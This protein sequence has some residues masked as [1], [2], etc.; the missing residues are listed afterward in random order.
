MGNVAFKL[1]Y[2]FFRAKRKT[3]VRFTSVVAVVG[4]AVGVASLI[5][6]QSLARGFQDEMRDKILKNTAHI[7]IFRGDGTE[8]SNWQTIRE[9]I[10]T[11]NNI[12]SIAPAS[13]ANVVLLTEQTNNYAL[14]YAEAK[15]EFQISIEQLQNENDQ[16]IPISIG[17][18]LA[19]KANLKIGG[20]AEIITFDRQDAPQ[21]SEI[22]IKEISETGLYEYDS[23][24]IFVTPEN[25]AALVGKNHFA[26]ILLNISVADIYAANRTAAEIQNILGADFR[27]L[28]WQEANQPL[29]AALSL[30]RKV[31]LAIISLIIFVA[32]LKYY[33]DARALN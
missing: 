24:R 23:T 14:L 19:R 30:E 2:K 3:L 15:D 27:T 6:A 26:P 8:I 7:S 20:V 13:F 18:E 17:R 11:V 4:I 33:N 5:A 1:A 21:T 28:S 25:F 9:R 29:F 22:I 31:S 32:V 12:K 10:S 16:K